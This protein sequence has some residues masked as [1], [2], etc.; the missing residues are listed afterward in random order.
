VSEE[1]TDLEHDS[2]T[3]G[4]ELETG[5]HFFKVLLTNQARMNPTQFLGGTPFNFE[6]DQWR[7][8]FNIT[9]LL[10]L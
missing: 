8:A 3:F 5:G 1:R 9:R 7:V 4:I 6:A 2:G 10:T